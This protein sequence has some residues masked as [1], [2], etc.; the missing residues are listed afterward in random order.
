[1]LVLASTCL[2]YKN[3]RDSSRALSTMSQSLSLLFGFFLFL[4]IERST[5]ETIVV[6]V[7]APIQ[8]KFNPEAI[9]AKV[10]DVCSVAP[11]SMCL[12]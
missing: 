9:P 2:Y 10:G 7:S 1:M 12:N 6:N 5:A 4:I 8:H 11:T 3:I